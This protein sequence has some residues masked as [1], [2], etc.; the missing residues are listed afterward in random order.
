MNYVDELE[1]GNKIERPL[2]GITMLNA[3]DSYRLYQ[4][5]VMLDDDIDEGVVVISVSKNSGADKA[6]LKKGDVILAVNGEKVS[7]AAYLK[8]ELYKCNVGDTIEVTYMRNGKTAKTK[9]TL[10]KIEE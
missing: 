6:G 9:V 8:Y 5:G 7:N 1:K 4:N 10:T 3:T 2:I